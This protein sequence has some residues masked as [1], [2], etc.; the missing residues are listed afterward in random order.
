MYVTVEQGDGEFAERFGVTDLRV[1]DGQVKVWFG[2]N[3][4]EEV[5]SPEVVEGELSGVL[6][7]RT[8]GRKWEAKEAIAVSAQKRP[9]VD[10]K[11][12]ATDAYPMIKTAAEELKADDEFDGDFELIA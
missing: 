1:Q 3:A 12:V 8:F 11:V 9:V 2:P 4:P 7:E 10:L 5:D 6:S